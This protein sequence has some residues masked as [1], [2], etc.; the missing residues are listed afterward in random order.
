MFLRAYRFK[1]PVLQRLYG[2]VISTESLH[3]AFDIRVFKQ[4]FTHLDVIIQINDSLHEFM[5]K[6][7]SFLVLITLQHKIT[8]ILEFSL[9]C[10]KTVTEAFTGI[11][12]STFAQNRESLGYKSF[13][14]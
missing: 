5:E 10:F 11:D 3:C 9:Q 2:E 7:R 13:V 1:K 4:R 12:R 8:H 14:Q 6:C